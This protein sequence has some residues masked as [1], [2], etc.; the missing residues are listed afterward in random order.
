MCRERAGNTGGGAGRGERYFLT[1]RG[2][3][4]RRRIRARKANYKQ[5]LRRVE[6]AFPDQAGGVAVVP[7]GRERHLEV[8]QLVAQSVGRVKMALMAARK[9]GSTPGKE[10]SVFPS[11]KQR[12]LDDALN[13][14]SRG[15]GIVPVGEEFLGRHEAMAVIVA[16]NAT[17]SA[18]ALGNPSPGAARYGV[19]VPGV[20]TRSNVYTRSASPRSTGAVATICGWSS[21]PSSR[22]SVTDGGKPP[23]GGSSST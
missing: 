10:Q 21:A 13:R 5:A 7:A 11:V 14:L 2:L 1:A 15:N 23:R 3:A 17:R 16:A 12:S 8:V 9:A 19:G 6:K 4:S 18:R 20:S 22:V